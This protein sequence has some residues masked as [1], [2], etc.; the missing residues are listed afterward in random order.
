MKK[1]AIL[2]FLALLI[3]VSY[4]TFTKEEKDVSKNKETQ[5]QSSIAYR[6]EEKNNLI[7]E[8][9][10][11]EDSNTPIT[12]T[13]EEFTS[14]IA[15]IDQ[16][17]TTIT[18]KTNLTPQEEK[19]LTNTFITLTDFIFYGGEIKGKTFSSLTEGAKQQ[20]I[21]LYEKIDTKIESV[22]PGYKDKIKSTTTKT[23]YNVKD[24]LVVLKDSLLTKYKEEIGEDRYNDQ[25]DTFNESKETMKNSFSPVIDKVVDGSKEIYETTKNKLN[26]WYQ[27]WKEENS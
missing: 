3:F 26:N 23:Y 19:T 17:V 22:F 8:T 24:K 27:T 25:V 4:D 18:S 21:E 7:T 15:T 20:V 1:V 6:I 2:I 12:L 11:K 13:E 9:K 16:D 5:E 14:Y 10:E